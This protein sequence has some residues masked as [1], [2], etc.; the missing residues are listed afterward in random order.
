MAFQA[1]KYR[2]KGRKTQIEKYGMLAV[3]LPEN[4][5]KAKRAMREKYGDVLPYNTKEAIEKYGVMK[6]GILGF[7]RICKCHPLNEGGY[8][9]VP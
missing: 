1:E 4:K 3:H 2:E 7:K 8:D 9:P 6:G 5:E